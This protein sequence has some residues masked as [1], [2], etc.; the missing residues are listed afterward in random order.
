MDVYCSTYLHL[1]KFKDIYKKDGTDVMG[2]IPGPEI[3]LGTHLIQNRINFLRTSF[4]FKS[5]T[6]CND[7]NLHFTDYYSGT[8]TEILL[9]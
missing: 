3:S 4:R 8:S 7:K 2:A 1:A 6:E 9:V 5:L